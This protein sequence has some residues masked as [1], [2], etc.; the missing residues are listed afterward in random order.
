MANKEGFH[1]IWS[2]QSLHDA[3]HI[4]DYLLDAFSNKEV[5]DFYQLLDAFENTVK[6]FPTLYPDSPSNIHLKNFK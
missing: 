6:H 5:D 4:K 3:L 1:V 2:E